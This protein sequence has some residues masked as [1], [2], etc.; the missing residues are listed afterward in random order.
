MKDP[1]V[2]CATEHFLETPQ[3]NKEPNHI[4]IFFFLR[5]INLKIF[6]K[7]HKE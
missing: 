6:G 4:A 1:E 2:S 5:T 3:I 7:N